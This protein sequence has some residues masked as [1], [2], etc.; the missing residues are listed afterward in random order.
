MRVA[1]CSSCG[2]WEIIAVRGNER[3]FRI[4]IVAGV[5]PKDL[6]AVEEW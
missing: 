2:D 1:T 5:F 3:S 6:A 4:E